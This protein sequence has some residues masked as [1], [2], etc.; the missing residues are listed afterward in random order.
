MQSKKDLS[1]TESE[2][3]VIIKNT[4]TTPA[5]MAKID[6]TGVKR[7][8]YASDNY[9]WLQPGESKEISLNLLWRDKKENASIEAS[10]WNAE[11]VK[12]TIK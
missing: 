3:E 8:C 1:A 6:V 10:A 11:P 4:G 9:I 7:A 12:V 2:L 5:F